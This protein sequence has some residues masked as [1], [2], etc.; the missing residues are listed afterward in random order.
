MLYLTPLAKHDPL[1]QRALIGLNTR[2]R[3]QG[4]IEWASWLQEGFEQGNHA[5]RGTRLRK[6]SLQ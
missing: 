3:Y 5:T 6:G 4:I 2:I 1:G